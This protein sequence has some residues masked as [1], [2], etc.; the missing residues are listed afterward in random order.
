[1]AELMKMQFGIWAPVW[2]REPYTCIRSG[3]G[4]P[5]GRSTFGGSYMGMPRLALSQY[6]QSYSLRGSSNAAS[7]YQSTV[8]TCFVLFIV[9]MESY[10]KA[11]MLTRQHPDHYITAD[12]DWTLCWLKHSLFNVLVGFLTVQCC[13][14]VVINVC[15]VNKNWC[16][17]HT[18]EF[19]YFRSFMGNVNMLFSDLIARSRQRPNHQKILFQV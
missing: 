7:N 4:S 18:F 19:R 15:L 6:S 5:M 11:V 1:M 13:A 16:L 8:A 12:W 14:D 9:D 17:H 2:G 3:P 10:N